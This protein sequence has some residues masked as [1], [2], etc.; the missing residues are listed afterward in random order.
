M[1]FYVEEDIVHIK[2][3]LCITNQTNRDLMFTI[4]AESEEDVK[5]GLLVNGQLQGINGEDGS[6]IFAIGGGETQ[7]FT[8]DF[9]GDFGG[10]LLKKDRLL[11]DEIILEICNPH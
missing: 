4:K 11:P 8:V 7:K 3:V 5:T 1:D 9:Q 6:G 2:Y 10:N